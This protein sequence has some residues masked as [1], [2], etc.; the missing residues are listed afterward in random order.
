M[1]HMTLAFKMKGDVISKHFLM[2]R[3]QKDS[4]DTFGLR[5]FRTFFLW[6]PGVQNKMLYFDGPK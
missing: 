5:T 2:L 3:F 1:K 6:V 4:L